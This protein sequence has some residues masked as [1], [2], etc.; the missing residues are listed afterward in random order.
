MSAFTLRRSTKPS[1]PRRVIVVEDDAV[2][3]L[4]IEK[5]LHDSGI[6]HVEVC[7]S[8][9]CTLPK[10]KSGSYDAIVLDGHLADTNEGWAIAELV[11]AMGEGQTRIVFQTGSPEEIPEH[12]RRLGPVLT[13]PYHPRD[14]VAALE[15]KPRAGLIAMLRGG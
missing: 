9:A 11:R 3:G 1:R 5:T 14:L 12:I 10:L 7:P 15:Q 2:H 13:K 8:T 4:M 6:E